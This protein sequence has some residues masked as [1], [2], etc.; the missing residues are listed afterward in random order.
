MAW[1]IWT[2]D[3]S[4]TQSVNVRMAW[5]TDSRGAGYAYTYDAAGRMASMSINGVLQGSYR[6][7]FAGRQAIRV[8]AATGVTIHSVFDSQGRRIAEY[9][10]ATGALI[11]EYVWLGW[12]P[13]AVIE[14]G[15][16]SY[17]RTDHI[18]RPV[19]ATNATTGVKTWTAS[20]DPF[21]GVCTTTG[22]PINA[23]F[24][25]QWFQAESGLHQNWMRDYDPTTGR[26][27]QA[28]PLGLVDGASVYGYAL[29]NPGRYV[30]PRGECAGPLAYACAA[31]VGAAVGAVADVL[32]QLYQ[33]GGDFGCIDWNRVAISAGIGA[34]G[35]AALRGL[36]VAAGL[37]GGVGSLSDDALNAAA[38][39][40]GLTPKAIGEALRWGSGPAGVAAAR[41]G[42]NRSVVDAIKASGITRERVRAL[43][44]FYARQA[45]K[46]KGLPVSSARAE[47]MRD[48]LRLW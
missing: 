8:I 11:R 34:V 6:Y 37:G 33:N 36:G 2:D 27:L 28:D 1:A 42:L 31:A 17:M 24:P 46:G 14:G 29:Q 23:R 45:A 41:A 47:Y 30:D 38:L 4:I 5:R 48:I 35:G 7:D 26:Y 16:V 12:E 19:F 13:V 22:S 40:N 3:T 43:A 44:E 20:Y 15:V 10:E 21:G 32:A 39:G 9:N 25:G 18:S